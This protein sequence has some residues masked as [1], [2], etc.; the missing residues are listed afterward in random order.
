MKRYPC[1]ETTLD[2]HRGH[3]HVRLWITNDGAVA[4]GESIR[5]DAVDIVNVA[6]RTEPVTVV[7]VCERIAES[8]LLGLA[9]V[10]VMRT[11]DNYVDRIGHMI[12]TEPF[13]T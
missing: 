5:A 7:S 12:Y 11:V 13:D 9:A 2:L 3:F 1:E 10:Q 8:G 4:D 6:I